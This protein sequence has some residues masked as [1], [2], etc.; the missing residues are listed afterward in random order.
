M[1]KI[2]YVFAWCHNII[3]FINYSIIQKKTRTKAGLFTVKFRIELQAVVHIKLNW[4][5]SRIKT[6]YIFSFKFDICI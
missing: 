1:E 6:T 3:S 4:V 2:Q 5:S